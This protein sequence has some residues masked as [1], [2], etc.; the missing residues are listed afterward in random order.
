MNLSSEVAAYTDGSLM[1]KG[2]FIY[3]GYGIY[4]PGKE[5]KSISRKFTHEPI[6]NNRAELYAILKTI[7]LTNKID[8]QRMLT[9]GTRIK[10]LRIYSDS[11]YSVKTFNEWL[12]KWLKSGKEYMNQ[13]IINETMDHMKNASFKIV[14]IHV[15]AHT[16]KNDPHSIANAIVDELAKKGAMQL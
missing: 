12:P 11:E 2:K 4:F 14:L 13:D 10:V 8:N 9:N 15:R 6:T 1:R 5:Y 16:G 3:C 7:I